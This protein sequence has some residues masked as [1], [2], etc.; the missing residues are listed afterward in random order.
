MTRQ[1][2]SL[3]SAPRRRGAALLLMTLVLIAGSTLLLVTSDGLEH[4]RL[5]REAADR[6]ALLR[7]KRALIDWAVL[8]QSLP[9]AL[10]CPDGDNDGDADLFPCA[11]IGRLPWLTLDVTE[12]R[13]HA[14]EPLWYAMSANFSDLPASRPLNSNVRGQLTLDEA[15]RVAAL[16]IAPGPALGVQRRRSVDA[17]DVGQFLDGENADRD[18]VYSTLTGPARNDTVLA[19]SVAEIMHGVHKRALALAEELLRAHLAAHGFHSYI[20]LAPFEGPATATRMAV[21]G[22]REGHM[23][24]HVTGEPYRTDYT[25]AWSFAGAGV[26]LDTGT[27]TLA[28][29]A[30]RENAQTV[31]AGTCLDAGG[32]LELFDCVQPA[33]AVQSTGLPHGVATR[34]FEFDLPPFTGDSGYGVDPPSALRVASR[35]VRL[36]NAVFAASPG[37]VIRVTDR[38]AD[39]ARLGGGSITFDGATGGDLAVRGLHLAPVFDRALRGGDEWYL[40]NR[41]HRLIYAAV[42]PGYAPGGPNDCTPGC[43]TLVNGPP[44]IDNKPALLIMPGTPLAGPRPSPRLGDYLEGDNASPGDDVFEA[45]LAGPAFND[46]LRILAAP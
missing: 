31:R 41:W 37:W 2:A 13:D 22:V 12:L 28:S 43:L 26:R 29:A 24:L 25:V 4:V 3:R 36:R 20:W 19:I 34:T 27:N 9:G 44:S 38:A 33:V 11:E 7:A 21:A 14:G 18:G 6:K 45:N 46:T 32:A 10:P 17:T 40:D 39:G 5:A 16:V 42:A 8:N 35:S 23:P 15:R 1:C 30:L